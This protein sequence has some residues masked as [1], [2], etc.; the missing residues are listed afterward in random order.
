MDKY[1]VDE[2]KPAQKEASEEVHCPVCGSICEQHGKVY[3]CP[4][5]GSKPFETDAS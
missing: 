4:V 2:T 3:L 1:G 5:H